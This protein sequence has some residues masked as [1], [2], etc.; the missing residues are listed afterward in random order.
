MKWGTGEGW[1]T[2][3]LSGAW[4]TAHDQADALRTMRVSSIVPPPK[5]PAR[6]RFF[7]KEFFRNVIAGVIAGAIG[8]VIAGLVLFVLL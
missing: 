8:G 5:P 4:T 1:G 6:E 7:T 2:A 3:L